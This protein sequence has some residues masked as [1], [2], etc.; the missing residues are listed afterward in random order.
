MPAAVQADPHIT[1]IRLGLGS[2]ALGATS[3][4]F[5]LLLLAAFLLA[6]P[7][8]PRAFVPAML[9]RREMLGGN[10]LPE[11]LVQMG[12]VAAV[13]AAMLPVGHLLRGVG[14]VQGRVVAGSSIG[15]RLPLLCFLRLGLQLLPHP[16]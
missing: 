12:S 1:L 14:R 6:T 15:Q 8:L 9:T 2:R 16:S 7:F 3:T 5:L 4:A 10:D 13:V 11:E